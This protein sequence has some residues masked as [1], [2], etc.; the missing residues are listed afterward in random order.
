VSDLETITGLLARPDAEL[1]ALLG[2]LSNADLL[3]TLILSEARD[4]ENGAEREQRTLRGLWYDLVK[5]ALS[6]CGRLHA[7]TANGREI[8]WDHL[9]SRYLAELVRAGATSYEDL[10]IVDDSRRRR[11]QAG[12]QSTR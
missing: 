1:R 12:T 9:L 10:R 7:K 5:P 3:R 8:A 2:P 6:R 11:G 4:I